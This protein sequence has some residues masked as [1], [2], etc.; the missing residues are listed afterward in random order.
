LQIFPIEHALLKKAA[1][2]FSNSSVFIPL[3]HE[4]ASNNTNW[5]NLPDQG[6]MLAPTLWLSAGARKHKLAWRG[7]GYANLMFS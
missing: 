6:N 4:V 1:K 3:S 5:E 2:D 7:Q